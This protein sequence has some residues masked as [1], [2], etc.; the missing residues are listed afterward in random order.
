MSPDCAAVT[1][2]DWLV[3]VPLPLMIQIYSTGEDA[4]AST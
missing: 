1:M 3:K 4:R 2:S